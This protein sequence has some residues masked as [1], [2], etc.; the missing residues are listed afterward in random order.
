M[1]HIVLLVL[2][3]YSWIVIGSAVLSWFGLSPDNPLVKISNALVDPVLAPIRKVVPAIGGLDFSPLVLL[4][5]IRFIMG[6][7][8]A[9]AGL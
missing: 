7:L 9:R 2:N 6:V 3:V 8:A 1:I 5:G 4:L